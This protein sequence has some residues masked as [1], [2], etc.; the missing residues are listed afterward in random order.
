MLGGLRYRACMWVCRDD[1]DSEDIRPE[2]DHGGFLTSMVPESRRHIQRYVGHA[3]VQTDIKEVTY[4]GNNDELVAAGEGAS[5]SSH[6]TLPCHQRTNYYSL[7]SSFHGGSCG[8]LSHG[9]MCVSLCTRMACR[10]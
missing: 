7:H 5:S 3:N 4:L 9:Y 6:T 2:L 10:Q 1:E 8:N